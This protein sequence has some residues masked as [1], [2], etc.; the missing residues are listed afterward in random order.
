MSKLFLIILL[1][2][3]LIGL[4]T[5][6]IGFCIDTFIRK[7]PLRNHNWNLLALGVFLGPITIFTYIKW[8]KWLI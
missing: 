2:W 4:I 5:V 1:C 8:I 3:M 6:G 7:I